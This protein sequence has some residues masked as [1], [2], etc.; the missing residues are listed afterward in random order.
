MDFDKILKE[1]LKREIS[2]KEALF[3]FRKTQNWERLLQLFKTACRVRDDEIGREC[4]LMGF[5]C[6][7]TPCN[8]DPPCKYCFRWANERL[9]SEEAVLSDDE[10]EIAVK[11]LEER[12]LKRVELGG[13]TLWGEEGRQRTLRA[14]K[15]AC[16][17]SRLE[18]WINNGPSYRVEDL[19]Q[20]KKLGVT[21]IACNL[22]TINEA[23]FSKM[24]PGDNFQ[25]RKAIIEASE[26]LGLQIDNTLMIG[27]GQQ[28]GQPHPY[29]DWVN[30]FYYFKQFK[31]LRI[32]EI[33]PFRPITN[34][35][36]QD[37]PA[38]S[39]FESE[40]ARAIARLIFRNIDISGGNYLTGLLAG[41][42]LIMHCLPI[43]KKFRAWREH[44]GHVRLVD[45]SPNLALVD[46][47]QL[48]TRTAREM[49]MEI[50]Q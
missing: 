24:R 22:E 32:I 46:N 48:I 43:T 29:E 16:K 18:I 28:A 41:G 6:C 13:G 10:L 36:V 42:N 38:G 3:L 12:G 40:K 20:M 35:P 11:T 26:R 31:N 17:S 50:E 15:V 30:F 23:V 27:L 1:A 9:F 2:P 39:E 45:L 19:P 8:T 44:R 5:I 25:L 34:S 4:K 7:I 37:W 47:L 49:G 14:V 21:G 33:H